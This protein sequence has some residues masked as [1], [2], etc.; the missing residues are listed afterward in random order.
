[1]STGIDLHCLRY[2]SAQPAPTLQVLTRGRRRS[3]TY[4]PS[5]DQA[6]DIEGIPRPREL[7]R[8]VARAR[9]RRHAFD[10]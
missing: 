3:E 7:P 5:S 1:M 10:A 2:H 4:L 9:G 6:V 8:S